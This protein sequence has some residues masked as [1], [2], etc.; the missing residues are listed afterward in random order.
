MSKQQTEIYLRKI[1]EAKSE[2][3]SISSKSKTVSTE[4]SRAAAALIQSMKRNNISCVEI[5]PTDVVSEE[6][7]PTYLKVIDL[8][9]REPKIAPRHLNLFAKQWYESKDTCIVELQKTYQ[10]FMSDIPK[11]LKDFYKKG[12]KE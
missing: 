9:P 10:S 5:L 3:S 2:K 4:H 12:K 11:H 7:K 8:T 1:L 6:K